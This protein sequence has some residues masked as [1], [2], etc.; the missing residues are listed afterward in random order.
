VTNTGGYLAR[1]GTLEFSGALIQPGPGTLTAAAGVTIEYDSAALVSG[2]FLR[3]PGTHV[4]TGGSTVT[5]VTSAAS[6]VINVTGPASLASFTNGADVNIT[7]GAANPTSFSLLTNEGSGAI[8]V[9]AGSAVNASDFQTYG[10]LT[11]NP[12]TTAAPTQLTNNGSSPLYFNGGSRTFISIPANANPN[13]F[14]AG[15]DLH[16]QNAVVAGGLLVNNGFIEDTTGSHVII[17]D[18]GSLVKGAGFFQNSVQT[19][20]GGKFQSGNSPGRSSFGSFTFGPGGVSNYIFGIDDATGTPGPSPDV[21][22]HVSGWGLV[23]VV[24]RLVGGTTTSGDFAWTA[25]PTKP[26]TVHLDTLVNPTT[27]GTD[28]AGPMADFDPA[29]PYSWLAA[30]WTG[31]YTGPSDPATLNAS[32]AFDTSGFENPISG[33]FGWRFGPDGRSL[34]LTY[35]PASVPEPGTLAL[36]A[37]MGLGFAILRR[38][39]ATPT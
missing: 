24:Q 5:G 12:N 3:G 11:L 36:T 31:T 10:T 28:V 21:N 38:R 14:D 37:L 25:D 33:Q 22:G 35:E 39:C 30:S 23:K 4:V 27:V 18:F 2:G 19:V 16:G 17:A 34:S 9:A 32:T 1:G 8:T 6:A 29:N 26:L 20:N 7:A 13:Q 15:I